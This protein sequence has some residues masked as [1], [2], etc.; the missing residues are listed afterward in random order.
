MKIFLQKK[1][2]KKFPS[3]NHQNFF[4]LKGL[5]KVHFAKIWQYQ[6]DRKVFNWVLKHSWCAQKWLKKTARTL[7]F[8]VIFDPLLTHFWPYQHPIEYLPILLVLSNS[9]KMYFR[10]SFQAKKNL[11][12]LMETFF[13]FFFEIFFCKIFLFFEF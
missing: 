10:K 11:V 13:D 8:W 7:G 2:R 3:K 6:K 1:N 5:S 4:G 9:G 12:I